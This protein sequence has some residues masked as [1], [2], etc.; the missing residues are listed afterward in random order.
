M[1]YDA[2]LF[3]QRLDAVVEVLRRS[4]TDALLLLP[5]QPDGGL[6]DQL[7]AYLFQG[8]TG[9]GLRNA[10]RPSMLEDALVVVTSGGA[11]HLS[12]FRAGH[13][14]RV[15]PLLAEVAGRTFLYVER[16]A[17]LQRLG[18][19][20]HDLALAAALA[21]Q[22]ADEA[23][24]PKLRLLS[25]LFAPAKRVATCFA[26]PAV[27]FP[28]SKLAMPPQYVSAEQLFTPLLAR[29]DKAACASLAEDAV[30]EVAR[31]FSSSFD[32]MLA[33]GLEPRFIEATAGTLETYFLHGRLRLRGAKTFCPV[34]GAELHADASITV[35]ASH[36]VVPLTA[37]R[38]LLLPGA[39]AAAA[40]TLSALCEAVDHL[41]AIAGS[42]SEV[43]T[44]AA[45][46]VAAA[47]QRL[48]T[49][50]PLATRELAA[51]SIASAVAAL[52]ATVADNDM[53]GNPSPTVSSDPPVAY[54]R[55]ISLRTE[56]QG[57]V[58]HVADTFSVLPSTSPL[59]APHRRCLTRDAIPRSL[60]A[61]PVRE[62]P[63]GV[64]ATLVLPLK[65][66]QRVPCRVEMIGQDTLVVN[67]PGVTV[68]DVHASNVSSCSAGP[69]SGRALV[70]P[71][72]EVPHA[73]LAAL[74]FAPHVVI[75]TGVHSRL[76]SF[77]PSGPEISGL[78]FPSHP[79]QISPAS[80]ASSS[81]PASPGEEI[82]APVAASSSSGAGRSVSTGTDMTDLVNPASELSIAASPPLP[83]AVVLVPTD[84]TP[85]SMLSLLSAAAAIRA[86]AALASPEMPFRPVWAASNATADVQA[87]CRPLEIT[88]G[89]LA[90]P[91]VMLPGPRG[92]ALPLE[93]D[94]GHANVGAVVACTS[95]DRVPNVIDTAGLLPRA[96]LLP[97][98]LAA[99]VT[100]AAFATSLITKDVSDADLDAIAA[101]E[102]AFQSGVASL[103]TPPQRPQLTL[104]QAADAPQLQAPVP[105]ASAEDVVRLA[106]ARKFASCDV[107]RRTSTVPQATPFEAT[108][109]L[110]AA[111]FPA[112]TV[113]L[114]SL[115]SLVGRARA[116]LHA[117]SFRGWFSIPIIIQTGSATFASHVL[118]HGAVP[119]DDSPAI[120]VWIVPASA[121]IAARSS[122][123]RGWCRTVVPQTE[124]AGEHE[125]ALAWCCDQAKLLPMD[126]LVLLAFPEP[127]APEPKPMW[128]DV[129]PQFLH[130]PLPQGWFFD[131]ATYHH[132][133]HGRSSSR[134]DAAAL[135][136]P[137]LSA[138]EKKEAT[139]RAA[140]EKQRA[141]VLAVMLSD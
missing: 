86:A 36:P 106:L 44:A 128:S 10:A 102:D 98:M 39:T 14:K 20:K 30:P 45:G 58:L 66:T 40:I 126:E 92:P 47:E 11:L 55:L 80:S 13:V 21:K 138:W 17:T 79:L 104:L 52:H 46:A 27:V 62:S 135:M 1:P 117:R 84:A 64:P 78:P 119:I 140:V 111:T 133:D 132:P 59:S 7:A 136:A 123:H 113:P 103:T 19:G 32:T 87:A 73:A 67:A 65:P 23:V 101:A 57:V 49:H 82:A 12:V 131:G 77:R 42:I 109:S 22:D 94:A 95:V 4:S 108:Q 54:L 25:A 29:F 90:A 137:L 129:A 6:T 114:Q 121:A 97:R 71:I 63:E 76:D 139:R 38:T 110:F 91:I 72:T 124:A 15:M 5:G 53:A 141:A 125:L 100:Q 8:R 35:T 51:T 130:L 88:P 34:G 81:R 118:C 37:S 41:G 127:A 75:V 16:A 116:A 56:V 28:L 68:F 122:S 48:A 60:V 74:A 89:V 70:V 107:A 105:G 99:G 33:G 50:L 85:P 112:P 120:K 18:V 26:N 61:G 3:R 9:L 43:T 24:V 69:R 96:T 2:S 93:L 83:P 134:P 31:L 115:S